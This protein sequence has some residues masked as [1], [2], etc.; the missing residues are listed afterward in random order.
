[1]DY[2]VNSGTF[3]AGSTTTDSDLIVYIYDVTNSVLIEPSSIKFFSNSTTISDKF[4]AYFQTSASGASYRLILHCASTSANAY[5]LEFDNF[6]VSPSQYVYG[7]PITDWQSYTPTLQGFGTV[8]SLNA[9]WRR[10]GDSLEANIKFTTGT[11]SA[12]QAQIGLPS[13][14]TINGTKISVDK[15]AGYWIRNV[16]ESLGQ[17]LVIAPAS[18]PSFVTLGIQATGGFFP[19]T[20]QNG[21]ALFGSGEIG[22]F[23]FTVPISGWSS[24]VQMSDSA[25]TRVVSAKVTTSS[26]RTINN[27]S[28]I[29]VYENV[30]SDTHGAYNPSTGE[31]RVPVSGAYKCSGGFTVTAAS[32]SI[33]HANILRIFKNGSIDTDLA[34]TMAQVTN[35]IS[36]RSYGSAVLN[37]VAGDI[38]TFRFFADT[39]NTLNSGA[40]GISNHVSISRISGPSAIAASETIALRATKVTGTHTSTGNWQDVTSYDANPTDTHVSFNTTTGVYTI[41]AAGIYSISAISSFTANTTGIRVTRVDVNG[42][43]LLYSQP[44]SGLASAENVTVA[45]GI[46][47]LRSG[48]QV[49]MQAFQ[50]SGGNLNYST[51]AG[52]TSLNIHRIGL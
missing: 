40:G 20:S 33:G 43:V 49:K 2:I 24:S 26:A 27:T 38:I 32:T 45:P 7:T 9:F 30:I 15:A 52:T 10:V 48:D 14:L 21:S 51:V 18:S 35:A 39:T 11:T 6:S 12:V 3:V 25:D 22:A 8:T 46:L 36:H 31:Y 1:M 19:F 34:A 4:S 23:Y 41:Q 28:P 13:G 16:G 29:I 50:N 42:S 37:L 17:Y 5:E 44:M 47:R